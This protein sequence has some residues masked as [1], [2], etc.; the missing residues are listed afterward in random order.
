MPGV[1]QA[2]EAPMASHSKPFALKFGL[3]LKEPERFIGVPR[4][5]PRPHSN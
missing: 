3:H 2:S 1:A 5:F 4:G